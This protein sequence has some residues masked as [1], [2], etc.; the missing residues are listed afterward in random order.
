M[1]DVS[2]NGSF[3]IIISLSFSIKMYTN[4]IE[5]LDFR[6]TPRQCNPTFERNERKMGGGGEGGREG[7]EGGEYA[8]RDGA[9][10][11]QSQR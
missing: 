2:I 3:I 5:L 6:A 1:S 9:S 4:R 11:R 10:E 8:S 7:R